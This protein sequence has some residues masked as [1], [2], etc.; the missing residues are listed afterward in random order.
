MHTVI[1]L[2]YAH[3]H[4]RNNTQPLKGSIHFLMIKN[5]KFHI[6]QIASDLFLG[7]MFLCTHFQSPS[8]KEIDSNDLNAYNSLEY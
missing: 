4:F 7:M 5:L 3:F 2:Q 6:G 8:I 1:V